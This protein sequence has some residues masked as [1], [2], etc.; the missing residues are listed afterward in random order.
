[1]TTTPA[2]RVTI[3]PPLDG[4]ALGDVAYGVNTGVGALCDVVIRRAA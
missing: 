2:H 3:D 1:M 4:P